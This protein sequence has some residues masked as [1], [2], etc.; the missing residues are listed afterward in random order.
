MPWSSYYQ[1]KLIDFALVALYIKHSMGW[2]TL[3]I[4]IGLYYFRYY[5]V[6]HRHLLAFRHR[7]LLAFRHRRL[8]AFRHRRLLVFRH[9]RFF[10]LRRCNSMQTSHRFLSY[11]RSSPRSAS[12]SPV[13]QC[14]RLQLSPLPP[15][16]CLTPNFLAHDDHDRHHWFY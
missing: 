9:R 12:H 8:I 15:P 10:T 3:E 6:R 2:L 11:P 16:Q 4:W 13:F 7:R 5:I 14:P 1:I